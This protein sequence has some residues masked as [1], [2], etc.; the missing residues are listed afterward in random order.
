MCPAPTEL[1][2]TGHLTES[3]W[4]QKSKSNMS[5][6]KTNSQ[7]FQHKAVSRVMSGTICYIFLTSWTTPHF[8]AA[9]FPTVILVFPQESNLRCRKDLRKVL[10]QDRQQ[11]KQEH[12]VSFH[13][14]AYLW[15]KIIRVTLKAR[16]V[17]ETLKSGFGKKEIQNP[18]GILFSMLRETESM[19][20]VQKILEV[21]ETHASGNREH[22]RKVVQNMKDRPRHDESRSDIS[23][24]SEKMHISIWTRF[25]ASS[26][27]AALHMDQSYE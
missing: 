7:T 10:R 12:V 19:V 26:M 21:S 3:T 25:M 9:T 23:M 6:P 17:Q 24:N 27:Q 11:R 15:D 22:T 14:K 4:T 16:G 1:L 18:D 2:S 5:N 13:V 8:P 20:M